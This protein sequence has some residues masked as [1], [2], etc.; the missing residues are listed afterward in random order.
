MFITLCIEGSEQHFNIPNRRE[1][2]SYNNMFCPYQMGSGLALYLDKEKKIN[3]L[4]RSPFYDLRLT[5]PFQSINQVLMTEGNQTLATS[6]V[7]TEENYHSRY[8]V[9]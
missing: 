4:F 1:S 3:A 9:M 8:L 6:F 2:P 5:R 7:G